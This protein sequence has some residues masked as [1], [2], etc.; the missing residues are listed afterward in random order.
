M[1]GVRRLSIV[2]FLVGLVFSVQAFSQESDEAVAVS[3]DDPFDGLFD[4]AEDI[5]GSETRDADATK[6]ADIPVATA[7]KKTLNDIISFNGSVTSS[8]GIL[9]YISDIVEKTD[10]SDES[11]SF[12]DVF[13]PFATFESTF[14]FTARPSDIF[15]FR[16]TLKAKFPDTNAGTNSI[17]IATDISLALSQLYFDYVL[18]RHVYITIGRTNSNWNVSNI[19]DTN[20]LNDGKR[21]N[22]DISYSV[23][24]TG[25]KSD[26]QLFDAIVLVPI[27][28]GQVQAVGMYGNYGTAGNN[29]KTENLSYAGSLEFNFREFSFSLF[30]RKWADN[31]SRNMSPALGASLSGDIKG[32]HFFAWGKFHFTPH[33]NDFDGFKYIKAVGGIRKYWDMQKIGLM[34]EYQYVYN[35]DYQTNEDLIHMNTV[36]LELIWRHVGGTHFSPAVLWAQQ[37]NQPYAAGELIPS[38]SW[39]GLRYATI[40]FVAPFF[41]GNKTTTYQN[42]TIISTET[43][44]KFLIGIILSLKVNF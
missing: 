2:L 26:S 19:F 9:S 44:P 4:G 10:D 35:R 41:Y 5:D 39:D 40:R 1:K 42:I 3:S 36:A 33:L 8:L 31:D 12:S 29:I 15:T 7:T 18:A 43:S 34:M 14:G 17:K 16:G 28:H 21:K 6:S 11:L 37:I 13:S 20:I 23:F 38:L 25:N 30:A 22:G 32:W 24:D 27:W